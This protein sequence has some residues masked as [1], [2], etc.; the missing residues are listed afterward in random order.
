MVVKG[1]C[2]AP[3]RSPS[4]CAEGLISSIKRECLEHLVCSARFA[5]ECRRYAPRYFGEK[6]LRKAVEEYVEHYHHERNHQGLGNVIPFPSSPC[7]PDKQGLIVKSERLVGLLNDYHRTSG[8]ENEK[9][10]RNAA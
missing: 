7:K 6:S 4:D 5:R 10:D 1:I 3:E 9:E 8:P 2:P